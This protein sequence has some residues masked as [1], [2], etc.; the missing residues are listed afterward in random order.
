MGIRLRATVSIRSLPP[1]DRTL[2]SLD[3][4]GTGAHGFTAGKS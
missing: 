1:S 4:E 3:R 2:A